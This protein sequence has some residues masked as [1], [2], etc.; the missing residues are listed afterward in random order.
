M[1][2]RHSFRQGDAKHMF[3]GYGLDLPSGAGDDSVLSFKTAHVECVE[4]QC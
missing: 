4:C 2:L 3:P 1:G